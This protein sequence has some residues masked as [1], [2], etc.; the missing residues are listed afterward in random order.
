MR[1]RFD[2]KTYWWIIER[3]AR[4]NRTV[5]F[6]DFAES[7]PAE[8]FCILRH[9]VDYSLGAA[10]T[11]AEQEARRAVFATYFLL[12]GTR[13]YNL[14][15]PD[16]A[17]VARRLAEMGHE[18][19][20]HYDVKF[21]HSFP[22]SDWGSLLRAQVDLLSELAGTEVVSIAMHQPA[23]HG[24]DPF[25]GEGEFINAYEERFVRETVYVSD[26]CRAWRDAGWR[27]LETGEIPKRLQVLLHPINWSDRDRDRTAIFRSVHDDLCGEIRRAGDEL[28]AKIAVHSGVA[29]HEQRAAKTRNRNGRK[30]ES[31]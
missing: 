10:L 9:D 3:I 19:G 30:A 22:R 2:F 7:D 12:V 24:D 23:L 14:V 13:Y 29:E 21:L 15:A 31:R 27:M 26:S 20:L 11:L 17:S 5:R 28:L 8:P 18:V 16:Y 4:T 6:R 25:V 1:D